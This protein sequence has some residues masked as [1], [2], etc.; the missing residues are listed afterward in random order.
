MHLIEVAE[1]FCAK[2]EVLKDK[3]CPIMQAMSCFQGMSGIIQNQDFVD[4]G[5]NAQ[6]ALNNV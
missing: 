4:W 5:K 1:V 6:E 2:N 3:F